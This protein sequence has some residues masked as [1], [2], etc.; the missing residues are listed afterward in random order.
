MRWLKE[1][2]GKSGS[3]GILNWRF[4]V[5]LFLYPGFP[6]GVWKRERREGKDDGK[7]DE[8]VKHG[9][10]EPTVFYCSV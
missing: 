6:G 3:I 1:R 8:E 9:R 4:F 10:M 2:R 5:R 7:V